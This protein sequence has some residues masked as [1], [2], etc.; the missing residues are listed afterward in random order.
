MLKKACGQ[1]GFSKPNR[2]QNFTS[3]TVKCIGLKDTPLG[4]ASVF[5]E[6]SWEEKQMHMDGFSRRCFLKFLKYIAHNLGD[7]SQSCSVWN[8]N[9][10]LF[11]CS[12][13]QEH[14]PQGPAAAPDPAEE[15]YKAD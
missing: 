14:L 1:F 10:L 5:P 11:F 9:H 15:R 6:E 8:H 7:I 13:I 12:A 2:S 3:C 4:Q